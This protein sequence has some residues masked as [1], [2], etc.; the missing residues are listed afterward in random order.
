V[1]IGRGE[2]WGIVGPNGA[3][4]T[5]LVRALLAEIE[6]D[7]G[8]VKLGSNVQIGYFRQ[9]PPEADPEMPVVRYIQRRV[10]KEND[11][12]Q[13]SEFEARSL[14]GAFLF[15]QSEQEKPLAVLSGGERARAD[16]AALLSSAKN[17]L[18]LDEPTNHLD[19][20][21]AERLEQALAMDG[22]YEGALL[23]I[24]HDR[25][26]LDACCDNLILLDGKG[27]AR[28]FTG[29]YS[30]YEAKHGPPGEIGAKPTPQSAARPAAAPPPTAESPP[31][32]KKPEPK[33]KSR[34]SW[35]PTDQLEIRINE[36]ETDIA[37]MDETLGG[38]EVWS[39]AEKAQRLTNERAKLK[40]ELDEAEEEWLARAE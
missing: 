32:P 3:G 37:E 38:T 10:A 39:D 33:R 12:L 16:L 26:M 24:S 2:R 30:E 7:A 40:A 21:S 9:T 4:K 19:I 15:S 11:G 6:P 18:V 13:L 34:F 22:G 36:L 17:L 28:V 25:A 27:A 31:E 1:S 5:T 8:S 29:T 35:M 20:P 23:L 14:A